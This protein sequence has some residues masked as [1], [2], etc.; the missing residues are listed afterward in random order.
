MLAAA[1][2]FA[3]WPPSILAQDQKGCEGVGY[4]KQPFAQYSPENLRKRLQVEP[5]D[6][7]TLVNLGIR[8]EEQDR[9]LEADALYERAIQAKPDCY[10]GYYF[11][12]LVSERISEQSS[13]NAEARI[14]KALSL[15]PSLQ[16]DGNVEGF[17]KRHP[18]LMGGPPTKEKVAPSL[19]SDLL[20]T[21]N[22]FLVGVGVGL[23]LAASFVYLAHR[24]R[25]TSG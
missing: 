8:L 21:A 6:V 20:A 2:L 19:M 4:A 23:L 14:H 11:A 12:G 7:D 18:Q 15:N 10:L 13:T 1:W 5:T 24:K 9:I 16:N 25:N 17:M 22:G 3:F